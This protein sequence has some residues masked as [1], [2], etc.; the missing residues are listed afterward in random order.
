VFTSHKTDETL[1]SIPAMIPKLTF[2]DTKVSDDST[3]GYTTLTFTPNE[4]LENFITKVSDASTNIEAG[5]TGDTTSI[6]KTDRYSWNDAD[7][8]FNGDKNDL[9]RIECDDLFTA[10]FNIDMDKVK[11]MNDII[12]HDDF[13][14]DGMF[15]KQL[16]INAS[17]LATEINSKAFES[18]V[19]KLSNTVIDGEPIQI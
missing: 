9:D 17:D 10:L 5:L 15:R 13:L 3:N 18:R 8:A 14:K 16:I 1:S 12:Y 6:V 7:R 11:K 19:K 4:H 2:E